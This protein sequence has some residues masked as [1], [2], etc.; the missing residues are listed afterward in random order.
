MEE[1]SKDKNKGVG[2]KKVSHHFEGEAAEDMRRE[3][4]GKR[5]RRKMTGE[6][7]RRGM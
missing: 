1:Q 7:Q 2:E 3:E 5:G 4:T 6:K